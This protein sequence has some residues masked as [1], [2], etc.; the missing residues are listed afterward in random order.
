MARPLTERME[1][2]KRGMLL[3]VLGA[4]LS[5][6]GC[7]DEDFAYNTHAP[8]RVSVIHSPLHPDAN[9]TVTI[10]ARPEAAPGRTVAEV[11]ITFIQ[12]GSPD[13]HEHTCGAAQLTAEGFC[14]FVVSGTGEAGIGIYGASM[15]DDAGNQGGAPA[16]YQFQIGPPDNAAR[17]ITV[18]APAFTPHVQGFRIL[19][20]RDGDSYATDAAALAALE[21]ALYQAVLEDPVHRW[22]D[23]QLAIFYTTRAGITRDY[24]S[25]MQSRCGGRPWAGFAYE[26]AAQAEAAFADVVGVLHTRNYRDCAGATGNGAQRSFSAKGGDP[27]LFQHELG[28]ALVGLSDEYWELESSRRMRSDS[29]PDP[30]ACNCCDPPGTGTGTG[31]GGTTTGDGS[32]TVVVTPPGGGI[33]PPGG[34]LACLPGAPPCAGFVKPARCYSAPPSCPPLNSTCVRPNIFTS[35]AACTTAAAEINNH[36]GIE[37]S[38]S[39]A[40]CRLLCRAGTA[41]P[42]PCPGSPPEVWILDRRVPPSAMVA[43]DDDIMGERDGAAPLERHGPACARCL[44][45]SYCMK[46]ETGR[47]KTEAEA[48]GMCLMP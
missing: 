11:R 4:T 20:V 3:A 15:T 28:H 45:T 6:N 32:G 12:P 37:L 23:E 1:R 44:E 46:W 38:A 25:G 47:G 27:T 26:A 8:P 13:T 34:G 41:T 30:I 14:R 24:H 48:Q 29:V 18:R 9:G 7:R 35:Q 42:C 16:S 21:N 33:T 39:A 36:P 19:M 2:L 10:T 31:T 5:C 22:R 17:V 40:D 43:L